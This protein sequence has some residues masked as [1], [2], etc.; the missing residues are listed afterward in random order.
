MT[1]EGSFA[2]NGVTG[3]V[4]IRGPNVTAGYAKNPKANTAGFADDP[5]NGAPW[6]R[7]GDL[8]TFDV[9]G[10]LH[11]NGRIKEIINRG[12]EKI[13]PKEIDDV[14]IAHPAVKQA[15]TFALPHAKLGED[16][17][18]AV[19]R[20]D[21]ETLTAAGLRKFARER[22]TDFKVP[23][24]VCFVEEIPKGPTGKLQRSGLAEK[25]GLV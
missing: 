1:E 5:E 18:V 25:L 17:A 24:T 7:T 13:S 12:G 6:F 10:Y 22:L 21:S 14:L 19:V 16:V 20:E 2:A 4:I 9:D 15:V 11:I 3:E 23:K 8:G